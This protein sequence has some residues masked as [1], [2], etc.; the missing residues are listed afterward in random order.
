MFSPEFWLPSTVSLSTS[1][2]LPWTQREVKMSRK[3]DGTDNFRSGGLPHENVRFSLFNGWLSLE[4]Q[5]TMFKVYVWWFPTIFH[6]QIYINIVH[7]PVET[8]ISTQCSLGYQEYTTSKGSMVQNGSPS[9]LSTCVW[10]ASNGG[11]AWMPWKICRYLEDHPMT[12][13]WL[14]TMVIASPLNGVVG[15]LP[16]ALFMAYKYGV[17]LTTY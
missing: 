4:P 13:K 14:I 2:N 12:C 1:W 15:P 10:C 16:N 9:I 3:F 11:H 8:T 17:I 5:I 6:V 7:H